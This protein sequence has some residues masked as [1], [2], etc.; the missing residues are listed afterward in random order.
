M[1]LPRTE[2]SFSF[3]RSLSSCQGQLDLLDFD[4][5]CLILKNR[6]TT[7][8]AENNTKDFLKIRNIHHS[9]LTKVW[10]SW[11]IPVQNIC[12]SAHLMTESGRAWDFAEVLAIMT[13]LFRTYEPPPIPTIPYGKIVYPQSVNE[14][15]NLYITWYEKIQFH[16]KSHTMNGL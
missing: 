4:L 1:K 13:I 10:L 6:N 9:L 8:K 16:F 3:T 2:I 12:D 14:R 15:C 11:Q 5:L 7:R